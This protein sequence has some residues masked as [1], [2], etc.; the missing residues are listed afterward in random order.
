MLARKIPLGYRIY[1]RLEEA[2]ADQEGT[3]DPASFDSHELPRMQ[4]EKQ[5]E[6][7]FQGLATGKWPA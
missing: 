3:G 4:Q 6:Q 1:F 7:E 2:V 5:G